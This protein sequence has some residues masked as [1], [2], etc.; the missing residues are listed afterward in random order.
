MVN[1]E[2]KKHEYVDSPRRLQESSP[3]KHVD[4]DED[5]VELNQEFADNI[6]ILCAKWIYNSYLK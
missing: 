2:T 5:I 4:E 3:I 6:P 1:W